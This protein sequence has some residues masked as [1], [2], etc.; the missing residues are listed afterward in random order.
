M[1]RRRSRS[2]KR[3]RRRSRR[4]RVRDRVGVIRGGEEVV[5]VLVEGLRVRG[6]GG[7]VGAE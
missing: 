1:R 4:R 6:R 7:G 3:R 2:R 5:N